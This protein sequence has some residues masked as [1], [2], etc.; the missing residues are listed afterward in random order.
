MSD[1]I[2]LPVEPQPIIRLFCILKCDQMLDYKEAHFF[3]S[4][5]QQIFTLKVTFHKSTERRHQ[6]SRL[7][8]YEIFLPR[9]FKND[10]M[11]SHW[12]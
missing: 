7:L 11:S 3:K 10:P 8:L 1:A 4:S 12:L 6:K 5:P 2:T 9:H